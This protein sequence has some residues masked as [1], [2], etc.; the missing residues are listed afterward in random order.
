MVLW[1]HRDK[2]YL[3]RD[4]VDKGWY[5]GNIEIKTTSTGTLL[6]RDG[7]VGTSR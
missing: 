3:N 4:V 6:T 2:D 7:T 5:C 1:D